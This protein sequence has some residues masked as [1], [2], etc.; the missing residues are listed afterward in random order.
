MGHRHR[1]PSGNL[2]AKGRNHTARRPQYVA[3]ANRYNF[4]PRGLLLQNLQTDFSQALTRSHHIRWVDRLVGRNHD[5]LLRPMLGRNSCQAH[6]LE[7]VVRQCLSH[8]LLH[9]GHVLM[10]RR[11]QN[12]IRFLLAKD[13][14]HPLLLPHVS[15]NRLHLATRTVLLQLLLNLKQGGL[16]SFY[17]NK[18]FGMTTP[19]LPGQLRPDGASSACHQNLSSSN[20]TRDRWTLDLYRLPS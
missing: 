2:L 10:R 7:G 11:M 18:T 6:R 1:S 13:R 16:A 14:L 19:N 4:H 17:Q 8:L 9:Q 12:Q 20:P 15:H 5:K 3:K